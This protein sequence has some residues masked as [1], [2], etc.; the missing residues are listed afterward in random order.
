MNLT[1]VVHIDKCSTETVV[2]NIAFGIK[3]CLLSNSK[4]EEKFE[5]IDIYEIKWLNIDI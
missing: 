1:H 5:H 4:F 2:I 3:Y